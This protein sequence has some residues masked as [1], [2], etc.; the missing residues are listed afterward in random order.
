MFEGKDRWNQI[1]SFRDSINHM[2]RLKDMPFYEKYRFIKREMVKLLN[3]LPK[4]E[5]E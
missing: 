2:D 1:I 3:E 4:F 5:N